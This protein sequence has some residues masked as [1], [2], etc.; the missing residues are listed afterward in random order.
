MRTSILSSIL[1]LF[2]AACSYGQQG[3]TDSLLTGTWK[4]TS[5][6]QV[7]PSPCH[8][9][10]AV[11]HISKGPGPGVYR[12][13]MNKLVN[14]VEEDMGE[15]DYSFNPKDN[16]LF[17]YIEKYKVTVKLT[18]KGNTMEGTLHSGEKLYRIIKLSK[19]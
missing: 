2:F 12:M 7:R 5:I 10:I 19:E 11:Y 8:D 4:G 1:M 13:V 9:E 17:C 6:C 16:T 15:S 18:I 14:G 3:N